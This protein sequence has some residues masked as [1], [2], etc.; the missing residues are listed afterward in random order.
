MT[1]LPFFEVHDGEGPPM[2]LVHGMLSSRAQWLQNL[3]RMRR[4][5]TPVV[6][7]LLGHAR[8]PAP[9]DRCAYRPEGYVEAFERIRDALGAPRWI[10]CG[11]SLGASLTL[12]YAL[13]HP[14]RVVGHVMTNSNSAFAGEAWLREIRPG[15]ERHAERLRREADDDPDRMRL[16]ATLERMS[17]HPA[18]ARRLPAAVRDALIEDARLHDARGIAHTELETVLHAPVGARLAQNR[19]PTLLVMGARERRF[20]AQAE[21]VA[22]R[23]P[24]LEI[25]SIVDAGHAVNAE[26]PEAFDDAVEKFAASVGASA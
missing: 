15:L 22:S 21:S 6:V 9:D 17:V 2:L 13:A 25:V 14:D 7:E 20:V 10:I 1:E 8:S 18:R 5:A 4:F 23:M 12:H 24:A 3:A 19:V 11:Q 16:A 26:A